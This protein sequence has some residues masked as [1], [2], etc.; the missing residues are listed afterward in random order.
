MHSSR[1]EG[2]GSTTQGHIGS[3]SFHGCIPLIMHHF[4]GLGPSVDGPAMV[5]MDP[6][7]KRGRFIGRQ[8]GIL[9][10]L[11]SLTSFFSLACV[12]QLIFPAL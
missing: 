2:G 9:Y 7:Q 6:G 10:F 12:Q 11:P 5:E 8:L 1:S 3:F 4:Q